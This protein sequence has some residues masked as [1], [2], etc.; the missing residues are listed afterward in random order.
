M[1]LR[2]VLAVVA[3]TVLAFLFTWAMAWW[4]RSSMSEDADIR[5]RARFVETLYWLA[6]MGGFV[7]TTEKGK[8]RE[9]LILGAGFVA[10][11]WL[12]RGVRL[13]IEKRRTRST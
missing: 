5:R 6:M 13:L 11:A 7:V 8:R 10:V 9:L 12:L 2:I 4:I 1:N 3:A